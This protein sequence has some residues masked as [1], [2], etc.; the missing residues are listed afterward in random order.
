MGCYLVVQYTDQREVAE[1]VHYKQVIMRPILEGV[2]PNLLPWS[3]QFVMWD[4]GIVLLAGLCLLAYFT[5]LDVFFDGFCYAGPVHTLL[6]S[7]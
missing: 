7:E 2:N 3:T 1:I 5:S 4:E 6:D